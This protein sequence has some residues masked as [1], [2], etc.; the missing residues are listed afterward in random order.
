VTPAEIESGAVSSLEDCLFSDIDDTLRPYYQDD[1]VTLYLGDSREILPRLD[2]VAD[3][4]VTDPPYGMDYLS[5]R[6]NQGFEKIVGDDNQDVARAVLALSLRLVR[7]GRHLYVFGDNIFDGL[8]VASP[9]QLAWDK[10]L[11]T[12]G[13]LEIPWGKSFESVW[14]GVHELSKANR[15]KGYGKG[16]ARLRRGSVLRYQRLQSGAVTRHPTE[17][18]VPL[19]RDLIESSSLSGEIVLD[20]FAGVGSTLVAATLEGR[21]SVGIE[22]DEGYCKIAAER[23]AAA[24]V[25]AEQAAAA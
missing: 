23:L 8:N 3:V 13:N 17:K 11:F 16:A 9:I 25:T 4:L 1:F 12:M 20:P 19:L 2:I 24:L 18:P 22:V 15:A 10:G 6:G 7:R 14:F 5:G 21:R